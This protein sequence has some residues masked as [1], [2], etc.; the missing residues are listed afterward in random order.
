MT[1]NKTV[2]FIEAFECKADSMGWIKGTKQIPTFTNRE[3]VS[4][5]IIKNYGQINMVTLKT[6]CERFCK[7]G[8]AD[9]KTRA[10]QSNKMMSMCLSNSLSLAA[11][12]CVCVCK[13]GHQW[14]G[15]FP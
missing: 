1:A 3:G 7:V 4:I 12:V 2:V 10:R 14:A 13:L 15:S 5:N 9:A 6:V 8:E 11:K